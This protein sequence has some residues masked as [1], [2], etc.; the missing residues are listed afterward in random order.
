MNTISEINK[1]LRQNA[2]GLFNS[3]IYSTGH[4]SYKFF[5]EKPT[6]D[7]F[8]RLFDLSQDIEESFRIVTDG[9]G[10]EAKNINSLRSSALLS[11]LCLNKLFA[12][13]C[14][15]NNNRSLTVNIDG[16]DIFFSECLFEV[17][18]QV[19]GFPSCVDVVLRSEDQKILLFLESK[20]TEYA[21]SRN[22]K[23]DYTLKQG[24]KKLYENEVIQRMLKEN[25]L[26]W[27]CDNLTIST[28][29]NDLMYF[30]GIKQTIS[31]LIGLVRGPQIT[32]KG[33]YPTEYHN[34]YSEWYNKADKLVYATILFDLSDFGGQQEYQKYKKLY[35]STI[36]CFSGRIIEAICNFWTNTDINYANRIRLLSE[37]LTY[38]SLFANPQNADIPDTIVK[39]FYKL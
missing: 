32:S 15:R 31:H 8:K 28:D 6:A 22:L 23:R 20:L 4:R 33:Y 37:P 39:Q 19:I 24:Y 18:N 38:Q 27:N 10:E 11:L 9:Q 35:K 7:D 5:K 17:R 1:L 26:H 12:F 25:N 30:E 29:D 13:P 14:L 36:G 2:K 21:E 16:V 34:M 3:E